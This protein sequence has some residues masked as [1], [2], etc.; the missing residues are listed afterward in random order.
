MLFPSQVNVT[1]IFTGPFPHRM[2]RTSPT[3]DFNVNYGC[4]NDPGLQAVVKIQGSLI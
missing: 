4:I 3:S 1:T 2:A